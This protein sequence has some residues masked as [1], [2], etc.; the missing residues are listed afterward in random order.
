LGGDQEDRVQKGKAEHEAHR[1]QASEKEIKVWGAGR[2]GKD[3]GG[4][5]RGV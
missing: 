2:W 3:I 1:E 5:V 4:I